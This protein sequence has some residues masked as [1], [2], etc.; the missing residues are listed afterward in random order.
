MA[1]ESPAPGHSRGITLTGI[2]D[3][4][5]NTMPIGEK[6]L[7]LRT[8]GRLTGED[9]EGYTVGWDQDPGCGPPVAL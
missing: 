5:S 6:R 3:G 2:L 8:L 9:N 1:A 4:I 7:R